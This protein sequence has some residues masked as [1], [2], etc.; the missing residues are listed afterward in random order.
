MKKC[1]VVFTPDAEN[2]IGAIYD[3]IAL[4][5]GLPDIAITYIR[6]LKDAC[7]KLEH[8]PIRGRDRGDI[9]KGL[10]IIALD[11]SAMAAFEVDEKIQIVTILGVFFGGQDYET[12]MRDD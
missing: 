12:I 11:K 8:A 2:N 9:R 3:Y 7:Y 5:K 6:K 10:R 4:D 1:S